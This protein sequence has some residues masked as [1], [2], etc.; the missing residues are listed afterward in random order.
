MADRNDLPYAFESQ[1]S[2]RDDPNFNRLVPVPVCGA[3]SDG[4]SDAGVSQYGMSLVNAD[5]MSPSFNRSRQHYDDD[6][7]DVDDVDDE[8]DEED[9]EDDD[10]LA[11]DDDVLSDVF[12]G[13][14]LLVKDKTNS[15]V[16][17]PLEYKGGA[18]VY[19]KSLIE[20][21][22]KPE[23]AQEDKKVASLHKAPGPKAK[24]ISQPFEMVYQAPVG[25]AVVP[26]TLYPTSNN[27]RAEYLK[28]A[29]KILSHKSTQSDLDN[30]VEFMR[31]TKKG[32]TKK[33]N[34]KIRFHFVE[35]LKKEGV[36]YQNQ[37]VGDV[38]AAC[39][40]FRHELTE[41][42]CLKLLRVFWGSVEDP[43]II[44]RMEYAVLAEC[45][46]WYSNAK[47]DLS[48]TKKTRVVG[49]VKSHIANQIRMNFRKRFQRN[50]GHGVTLRVTQPGG[51]HKRRKKGE[52]GR[53]EIHGWNAPK[54]KEWKKQNNAN[55]AALSIVPL[56]PSK[57]NGSAE[58]LAREEPNQQTIK[59][60]TP[61]HF[62]ENAFTLNYSEE[63]EKET[64]LILQPIMQ[65]FSKKDPVKTNV[66]KVRKKIVMIDTMPWKEK[67]P[68]I[69]LISAKRHIATKEKSTDK[70]YLSQEKPQARSFL[71]VVPL[72]ACSRKLQIKRY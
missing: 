40:A 28:I 60:D 17:N 59:L 13:D 52:F 22:R 55:P 51:R 4:Y 35:Q 62:M 9:A 1:A 21:S 45:N 23:N 47:D 15:D 37:P 34:S 19:Y 30:L 44:F 57:Q 10:G 71:R 68:N 64:D 32:I 66:G 25:R 56:K 38:K 58:H 33:I 3:I 36:E 42:L 16:F 5:I 72:L 43:D 61:I 7:D 69:C 50:I 46:L 14:G 48:C 41:D 12:G 18:L 26:R 27:K 63:L 39:E 2:W 67:L 29:T 53:S 6:V 49:F 11:D 31:Q 65:V 54:H 8:E 70:L 20:E 24:V